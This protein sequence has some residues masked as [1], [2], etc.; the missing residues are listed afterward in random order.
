MNHKGLGDKSSYSSSIGSHPS[1]HCS[2]QIAIVHVPSSP[3]HEF[4][5]LILLW[6]RNSIRPVFQSCELK[7]NRVIMLRIF[8][9]GKKY[10]R[11]STRLNYRSLSVGISWHRFDAVPFEKKFRNRRA[12]KREKNKNKKN[13]IHPRRQGPCQPCKLEQE[14]R[15]GIWR[16]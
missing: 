5:N 16:C 11:T 12:G 4:I 2:I 7:F 9:T 13:P 1:C 15:Y 14:R 3:N 8:V 6:N 10:G